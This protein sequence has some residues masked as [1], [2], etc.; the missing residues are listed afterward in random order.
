[1]LCTVDCRL[2]LTT[3]DYR[4][5][6]MV[7]LVAGLCFFPHDLCARATNKSAIVKSSAPAKLTMR[8]RAARISSAKSK[9][10]SALTRGRRRRARQQRRLAQLRLEPHRVEEIQMALIRAGYLNQQPTGRWDD[11]TR[12]AMRRYQETN[13]FSPSGL[14]D[15]KSLMKLGLGPHPLPEDAEPRAKSRA[16][17]DSAAK[18]K[19]STDLPTREEPAAADSPPENH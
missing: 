19:L 15:A 2:F 3:V 9:S 18:S 13:R 11:P 6:S 8:H 5:I 17:I 12:G 4:L 10:S 16:S 14:P 1:M 7:L